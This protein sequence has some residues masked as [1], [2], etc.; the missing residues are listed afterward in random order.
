MGKTWR[1]TF[2]KPF[3]FCFFFF[4]GSLLSAKP[5][6]V[7]LHSKAAILINGET[8]QVL[9]EK[10]AF[11]PFYPASIT[12]IATALYILEKN[13]LNALETPICASSNALVSVPPHRKNTPYRLETG[14]TIIGLKTGEILSL[15]S[16][17]YGLV[18]ASGGDAAN[19]LAEHFGNDSIPTFMEQL[20]KFLHDEI[21]CK[22]T[23]FYNP[24][25]LHFKEHVTTASDM[26][27]IAQRA[28]KHPF[29]KEL[30]RTRSYACS[31]TNKQPERLFV[32]TNRL[33]K[34]GKFF[35]PYAIGV[36]TG[37]HS[38]A[39][40]TLVA[41][42]EQRGRLLIAVL[43]GC[44]ENEHRYLDAKK[45]FDLAF[46][47]KAVL[48]TLFSKEKIFLHCLEG[49]EKPLQ[50]SLAEDFIWNFFPSEEVGAKAFIRWTP[51]PFPIA[52]GA[53]VGEVLWMTE[54]KDVLKKLPLYAT[55]P[56]QGSWP[57]HIKQFFKNLFRL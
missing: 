26:S 44:E 16:L 49:G 34:R 1:K 45:L 22:N 10:N 2:M 43:L 47:E 39:G 21:G 41:A 27:L 37:Y 55:E 29:F 3:C 40:F 46:S 35:Y 36:K 42:A 8:G 13:P 18:V 11:S 54:R 14:A 50:A 17:L 25:G 15:R 24:H 4:I 20:N 33:V 9:F 56:L 31:A 53:I 5:L 19:V 7:E 28:L 6:E 57:F 51:P 32:Q 38:A 12:K 23:H 30:V 52:K 48:Q